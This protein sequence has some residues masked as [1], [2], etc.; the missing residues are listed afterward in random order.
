[1][2]RRFLLL[3]VLVLSSAVF[4]TPTPAQ[5]YLT[6]PVE[7]PIYDEL[8]HFRALGYWRQS[9]EIRPITRIEAARALESIVEKSRSTP[10][11]SGDQERLRRLRAELTRIGAEF[12]P[13]PPGPTAP[14]PEAGDAGG[15]AAAP[16]DRA[17]GRDDLLPPVVWELAG[18]LQFFGQATGLDSLADLDRRPRRDEAIFLSI[19][20]AVGRHL[21]AETRNYEDYSHLTSSPGADHWV[22]NM[23][24]SAKGILADPSARNNRAVLGV[25]GSWF[26]LSYGRQDRHWGT[27]RR[28]TLFLSENPFPLDGLSFRFRT[29]YVSG[30]SLFAQTLRSPGGPVDSAGVALPTALEDAYVAAH[31]FEV[32]PPGRFRFGFFEAVVWGGRGIDLGYINPVGFLVAMTQDVVDRSGADDKKILG[33]DLAVDLHPVWLYGEFLLNRLITMDAA[34]AGSE[35]QISSFAELVGLRWADPLR[36]SGADLDL[37]YAHLDPE[38]YFHKDKDHRFAYLTEGELIGH[39]AGPNSDV[40]TAAFTAPPIPGLGSLRLQF[41]QV[42]W[43]LINGLRGIDA[44]FVGLEK[45]EKSWITG[46][47]QVERTESLSWIRS[48]WS[49]PVAGRFDS[50]LT[51][52]RV[53]R[54]GAWSG[55]GWQAEI[56][57]G[58]NVQV[59]LR[60]PGGR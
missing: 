17:A 7:N 33:A 10:L 49:A 18:G 48:G 32:H 42:R 36:L 43:G 44:G 46:P 55:N 45:K 31:R 3:L 25:H 54:T 35:A 39:W 53:D 8:E 20:A 14:A 27:G 51:L 37:E 6:V 60:D 4:H 13:P 22:D 47:Q 30:V 1:V 5:E 19:N 34:E 9:L 58:W 41:E 12:P 28:G 23:P 38:V 59:D 40:L 15:S 26:D 50:A 24:P 11:A 57:L 56:R 52:A 21:T 29:R 2:G 16:Q